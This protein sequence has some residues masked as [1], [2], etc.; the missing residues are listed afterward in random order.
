MNSDAAT[1]Y[2]VLGN[3]IQCDD[4]YIDAVQTLSS[5]MTETLVHSENSDFHQ[6]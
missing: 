5:K 2:A 6:V 3:L 4:K 1:D